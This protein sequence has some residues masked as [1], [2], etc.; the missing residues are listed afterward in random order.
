M[1]FLRNEEINDE[2]QNGGEKN[3]AGLSGAQPPTAELMIVLSHLIANR[4]PKRARHNVDRPEGEN[5]VNHVEFPEQADRGDSAS[6]DKERNCVTEVEAF[7][8]KVTNPRAQS[9]GEE[10]CHP[11]ERFSFVGVDAVDRERSL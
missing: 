3:E 6:E 1:V 9:E 2:N 8:N 10:N 5:M 4:S 11:V 7:R